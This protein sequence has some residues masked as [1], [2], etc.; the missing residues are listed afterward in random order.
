M[1]LVLLGPPGAGKGTHG[2][3]LSEKYRVPQLAAGDIF[4]QHIRKETPLGKKAKDIIESGNLVSDDL[5]N[6]MM[7]DEIRRSGISKGFI[8]DGYP[9]TIGQ[10]DALDKFTKSEKAPIDAALDFATSE[11]IVIVRLSGRRVCTKCGAN[12]HIHNI[13]PKKEGICDNCGE[14]LSQRKD[15][16]PET[17]KHRL[18]M[19]GKETF[20]LI[21]YYKKK[22]VLHEVP[23]DYEVPELQAELKA[24]FDRLKLTA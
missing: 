6:E 10:A 9:R 2:R 22:G 18:E 14:K 21:D 20:P 3:I 4:R 23:G 1:R 19:Y 12:Y 15:D 8:L 24:L 13:P 11:K 16:Q 5:V 7:F 17:I